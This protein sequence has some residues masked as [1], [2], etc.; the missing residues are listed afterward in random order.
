MRMVHVRPLGR[1]VSA[2]GFGCAS[3][4]SRISGREGA[5]AMAQAMDLGVSWFD[6]APPYGDGMAE[7]WLGRF[8]VG[9]R[10][11]V[12]ICSKVGIQRPRI[13]LPKRMLRPLARQVVALFPGL[14]AAASRAHAIESRPRLAPEAIE[15]SVIESLRLLRTDYLDVLALHEPDLDEAADDALF[16]VL[17]GLVRKGLVR[18]LSVA[19]STESIALVAA[20]RE[21]AF[22]QFPD[23]PFTA[24]APFLRKKIPDSRMPAL[25]THGVFGSGSL[26]R[27]NGLP[28]SR[29]AA[30][31]QTAQRHGLAA[32][33]TLE[34]ILLA[35]AFANNPGGTVITSMF[36]PAHI[37]HNC[38]AAEKLLPPAFVD[39]V[40]HVLHGEE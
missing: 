4:G 9:R 23:T 24:A 19:G 16:E 31:R 14:R 12:V 32:E 25:I 39:D 8:L 26:A 27:I 1:D 22:A 40:R 36:G 20:R 15:P 2:V 33:A 5:R 29:R 21:L 34:D 3:L 18:A 13:A 6:V 11:Q 28:E 10:E 35:F 38:A 30:L 17:E 37:V 7:D